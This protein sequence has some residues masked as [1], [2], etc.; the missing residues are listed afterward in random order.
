MIST[1]RSQWSWGS[2]LRAAAVGT[3]VGGVGAA[4]FGA[5]MPAT[6]GGAMLHGGAAGLTT[7]LA[8]D[9]TNS[10]FDGK[11]RFSSPYTYGTNIAGGA[12]IAGGTYGVGKAIQNY[13][14]ANAP[15]SAM[16]E[17]H[18]AANYAKYKEHLR[19]LEKY[20]S[21]GTKELQNNRIRY[22]GDLTKASKPGPMAGRRVV[23]EWDPSSGNTRIWME[24][25]DH[26]SNVRIVR[27]ETGGDKIHYMF[28]NKG[29]FTGT[30]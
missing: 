16:G 30:F 25:V 13:R 19:Q 3:V 8:G 6:L 29:T 18:N 10:A 23:R 22:Y 28:D 14:A 20:G 4:T 2:G 11:L 5:S 24:T 12:V 15:K 17:A 9:L 7:T 1:P 21:G 26:N 27:P